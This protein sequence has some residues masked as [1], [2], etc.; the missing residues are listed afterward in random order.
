[1]RDLKENEKVLNRLPTSADKQTLIPAN[2]SKNYAHRHKEV[3]STLLPQS[4]EH[5]NCTR[6]IRFKGVPAG[7][8]K[9]PGCGISLKQFLMGY[10]I[11]N[12]FLSC[13]K[14]RGAH[15]TK[16]WIVRDTKPNQ[17]LGQRV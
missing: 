11:K 17:R 13:A 6:K 2:I 14:L 10:S 3:I 4:T 16:I 9:F 12:N 1:M 15:H 7:N 8:V 5:R